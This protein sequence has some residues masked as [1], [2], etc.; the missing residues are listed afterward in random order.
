MRSPPKDN[1]NHTIIYKPNHDWWL[2]PCGTL[3]DLK[4]KTHPIYCSGGDPYLRYDILMRPDVVYPQRVPE[5][6]LGS[7]SSSN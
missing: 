7:T 2:V 4:F 3:F 1:M 6:Q 5:Q